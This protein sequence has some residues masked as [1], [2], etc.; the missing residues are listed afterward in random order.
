MRHVLITAGTK[1][2][3]RKITDYFLEQGCSVTTTY[4]SDSKRAETLRE[5]YTEAP[6]HITQ[7]DV[8]KP[9]DIE[10]VIEEAY[11]KYGR[12]DCLIANAGPFVFERKKLFDYDESEWNQMIRGNLD[13]SFHLVKGCLPIMRK[14]QFGRIVFLGF[15]GVDHSSG[16]IYRSAFAAAKVGVASLMKTISLEEAEHKITANMVAPGKITDDMKEKTIE[17]SR[18]LQQADT[19]VG[20]EG[21]GEDIARTVG[22]LCDDNSDMITGTVVDVNGGKDVI[23]RYL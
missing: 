21:T 2:L 14:Q 10:R 16:W 13:A 5:Q 17:E 20:R 8:T 4:H 12:I 15:Q 23:H 18:Q 19:P 6:L 3:G 9:K 7:L 22:F 1:G 11:E